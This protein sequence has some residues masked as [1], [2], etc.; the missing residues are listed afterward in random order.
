MEFKTGIVFET[1]RMMKTKL[2]I[3]VLILGIIVAFFCVLMTN[4]Y[5]VKKNIDGYLS[6]HS[7]GEQLLI[8]NILSQN[9]NK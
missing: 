7:N 3:S 4:S 9:K 2:Q 6:Y 5:N 8:N 1:V